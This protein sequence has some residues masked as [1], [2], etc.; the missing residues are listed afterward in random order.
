[1]QAGGL[2]GPPAFFWRGPRDTAKRAAASSPP[3][4]ESAMGTR[5][6]GSLSNPRTHRLRYRAASFLLALATLSA[7]DAGAKRTVGPPPC[8]SGRFVVQR[9]ALIVGSS[10]TRVDAIEIADGTLRLGDRC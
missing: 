2:D 3:K 4:E 9:P 1:M 7:A 5:I 10:T 8:S 6:V